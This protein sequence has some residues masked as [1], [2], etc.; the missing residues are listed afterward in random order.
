MMNVLARWIINALI[1]MV[2]AYLLP[3]VH[4]ATYWTALV[5]ALILGVLNVLVRPILVLLTLPI[6]ALTFGLFLLVVNAIIV[7]MASHIVPGFTVD[8][9]WWACFFSILVSLI[10]LMVSRI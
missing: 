8:S 1:I 5:V 9:F 2:A 7:I 4:V 6:T 10:N 3:G